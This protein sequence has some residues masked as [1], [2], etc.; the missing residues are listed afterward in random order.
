MGTPHLA[1]DS[2]VEGSVA[3]VRLVG[4]LDMD[5]SDE[6]NEALVALARNGA[7][8]VVVDASGLTFIDSSGLR[9]LLSG[10]QA[11]GDVDIPL[12]ID[13]ASPA[14]ERV[15]EITGTAALLRPDA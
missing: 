5:A 4:E 6:V 11:L 12:V 9:A 10:R 1:I 14:V 13:Q 7:T 15:L 2:S 8:S 3:H